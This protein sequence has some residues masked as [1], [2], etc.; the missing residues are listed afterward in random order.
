VLI[1]VAALFV[2][3][4]C[5]SKSITVT[6]T[7]PG[8]EVLL[9]RVAGNKPE[10]PV[11]IGVAPLSKTLQFGEGV[12]YQLTG[13]KDQY[14][15]AVADVPYEPKTLNKFE[16]KMVQ[17]VKTVEM[18]SFE[19]RPGRG[20]TMTLRILPQTVKTEGYLDPAEK[21]PLV[22]KCEPVPCGTNNICFIA[23]ARSDNV[24]VFENSR[25]VDKEL[26][27]TIE[28]E[29]E[30]LESIAA[31]YQIPVAEIAE[32]NSIAEPSAYKIVK[33][34]ALSIADPVWA[35]NLWRARDGGGGTAQLTSGQAL[36]VFPTL[37]ALGD[38]VVFS[39]NSAGP[40]LVL[41]RMFVDGQ[42]RAIAQLTNPDAAAIDPSVGPDGQIVFTRLVPGADTPQICLIRP[43]EAF[44]STLGD[45]EM[46]QISPDGKQICFL[47]RAA[48]RSHVRQ[49][50]L[51]GIDGSNPRLLT[52]NTN[53][54]I[55]QPRWH[56]GGEWIAYAA[57]ESHDSRGKPDYDIWLI[58]PDGT[59]NAQVTV[60]G[61]WD[62]CPAW[63]ATGHA[64]YFRSN[65]GGQWGIWRADLKMP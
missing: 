55:T 58:S 29:K 13:R 30:T 59:R 15:D 10:P 54:E 44:P 14:Y 46:A 41:R 39:S 19:P 3:T 11:V 37:T 35:G 43:G 21:S 4:G 42:S 57:N 52:R 38:Q 26:V 16:L 65:R 5:A 61:S 22:A 56:P 62:D 12:R 1:C 27:H 9:T 64:I 33:G 25:I 6:A 34:T 36:D 47:R 2:M 45:G 49:L 24:I 60:N 48:D 18:I 20:H 17:F 51:M 50:W 7:A 63:E 23:G 28:S 32:R 8:T 31:Q 40:N 53:F